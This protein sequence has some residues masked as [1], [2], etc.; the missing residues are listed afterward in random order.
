MLSVNLI[1]HLGLILCMPVQDEWVLFLESKPVF[2]QISKSK[3]MVE[4]LK[5]FS[6]Q[7]F[8]LEDTYFRFPSIALTDLE[9]ILNTFVSAGLVEKRFIA[10][11]FIFSINETGLK[12]L[13]L[14]EK[15]EKS[16][17]VK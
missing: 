13:G 2:W 8:S 9:A 3:I 17:T 10:G 6:K 11:N 4:I 5:Q 14:Y 16:F 7:A 12:F 1:K 15:A